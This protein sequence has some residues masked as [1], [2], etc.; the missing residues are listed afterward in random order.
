MATTIK[1]K[2][3]EKKSV[4]KKPA[5]KQSKKVNP[6]LI[7]IGAIVVA[8]VGA[9]IVRGSFAATW[10]SSDGSCGYITNRVDRNT[11]PPTLKQGSTGKCVKLLQQGLIA[12]GFLKGSADG[13]YGPKTA[14]SVLFLET[15]YRFKTQDRVANKCTWVAIQGASMYGRG[16]VDKVRF[17]TNLEGGNCVK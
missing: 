8:I 3:P 6:Y 5:L 9:L 15:A 13:I 11:K 4:K 14:D 2:S 10:P 7:G 12:T 17:Y 1:K 16:S